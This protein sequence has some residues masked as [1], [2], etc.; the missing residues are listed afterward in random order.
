MLQR[1]RS[2]IQEEKTDG[3]LIYIYTCVKDIYTGNPPEDRREALQ[4][5]YGQT[6]LFPE[7]KKRVIALVLLEARSAGAQELPE[8]EAVVR[9]A[10]AWAAEPEPE[11]E[12]HSADMEAGTANRK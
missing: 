11:Q 2:L 3:E 12:A 6:Y 8:A 10:Q 1:L 7:D 9:A 4:E 5:W